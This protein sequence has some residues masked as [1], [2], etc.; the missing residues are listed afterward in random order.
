MRFVR[1]VNP[2]FSVYLLSIHGSV[3]DD[4]DQAAISYIV[5]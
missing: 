4:H 2:V 1:L 5:N 3:T